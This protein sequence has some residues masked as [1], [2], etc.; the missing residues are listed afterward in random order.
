MPVILGSATKAIGVRSLLDIVIDSFPSPAD[1]PPA[2]GTDPRTK[3]PVTRAAGP[4]EPFSA[5]VFKTLTDAHVGKLSLFRVFSGALAGNSQVYN[6]AREAR[7]RVGQAALLQG[8]EQKVVD[9]LGPG[10]IGVS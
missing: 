8:R 7:E 9:A 3:E 4:N 1:R 6:P 5:L 2:E 10:Q